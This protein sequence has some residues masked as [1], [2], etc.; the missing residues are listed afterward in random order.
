MSLTVACCS[1]FVACV[2][3]AYV[4]FP[5]QEHA[6]TVTAAQFTRFGPLAL[7]G[8]RRPGP[9]QGLTCLVDGHLGGQ[10]LLGFS[11]VRRWSVPCCCTGRVA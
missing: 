7:L 3:I 11:L 10:P 6:R 9:L 5:I 1:A 4:L 8:T 2:L